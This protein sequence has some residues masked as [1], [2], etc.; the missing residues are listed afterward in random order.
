MA[1]WRLSATACVR[2]EEWL[3]GR[4]EGMGVGGSFLP[5]AV[6]YRNF[7]PEGVSGAREDDGI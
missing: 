4:E 2:V 5:P 3:K 7:L 1:K 6:S